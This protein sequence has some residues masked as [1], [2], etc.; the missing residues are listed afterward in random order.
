MPSDSDVMARADQRVRFAQRYA[1]EVIG[2]SGY[3]PEYRRGLVH[4]GVVDMA[5]LAAAGLE[6]RER[7]G[8]PLWDHPVMGPMMQAAAR[9]RY[10]DRLRAALGPDADAADAGTGAGE[11][12]T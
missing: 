6:L 7:T 4:S 9:E 11:A 2:G 12:G 5:E 10:D 8:D 1:A 3:H